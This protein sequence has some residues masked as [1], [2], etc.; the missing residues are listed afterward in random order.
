MSLSMTM[1][2]IIVIRPSTNRV[3]ARCSAVGRCLS[4]SVFSR[5]ISFFGHDFEVIQEWICDVSATSPLQAI[6]PRVLL[7]RLCDVRYEPL[8]GMCTSILS[9]LEVYLSCELV[10]IAFELGCA[11]S[12][13]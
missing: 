11:G 3:L 10:E 12:D 6:V 8:V 2:K 9:I 1:S 7:W 4:S 5:V 13:S